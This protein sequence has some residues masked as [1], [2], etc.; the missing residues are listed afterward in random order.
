M[1]GEGGRI[2]MRLYADLTRRRRAHPFDADAL[3]WIGRVE[4]DD[5][6]ALEEA[7]RVAF[8]AFVV[9]L[10]DDGLWSLIDGGCVLAGARTLLGAT[11]GFKGPAVT[12]NN[13]VAGDYNRVT[14][15][16][17]NGTDKWLGSGLTNLEREQ[18]E[19]HMA[20]FRTEA[21][22]T[23]HNLIGNG[24]TQTGT[25]TINTTTSVLRSQN[26]AATNAA[27]T[28]ANTTTGF[29]GSF[30]NNA[31]EIIMMA[32]GTEQ[33]IASA[34]DGRRNSGILVFRAGGQYDGGR[35]SFYSIGA[36][37]GAGRTA[38]RSRVNTLMAAIEDALT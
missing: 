17:G 27:S 2:A 28:Y 22:G 7:V 20:L 26:R 31:S 23:G 32:G 25:V 12:I 15:L 36:G 19:F 18:D 37:L 30:R 13:F 35:T 3:A 14:G 33:T 6:E 10:K 29:I 4:A 21:P 24:S 1:G 8:N 5:G 34:S 11:E 38:L 16:R 9:G